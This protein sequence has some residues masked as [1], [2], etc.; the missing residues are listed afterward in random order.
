MDGKGRW[1]D[2]V[3]IERLWKSVKYQDVYIKEYRSVGELRNGLKVW[4][5]RYDKRRHQG[6]TVLLFSPILVTI[7]YGW[8]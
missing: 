1:I 4:F 3:F 7:S 6:S 8:Q 2:N 5:A